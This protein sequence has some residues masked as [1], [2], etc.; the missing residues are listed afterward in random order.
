MQEIQKLPISV[1]IVCQNEEKHIARL[2]ESCTRFAEVVVVDSGSTDS[3]LAILKNYPVKLFQHAWQGYAKQKQFALEQCTH[4]WVLNLDADEELN[5]ALVNEFVRVMEK[6]EFA[7][8]RCLRDDFFMGEKMHPFT[9]KPNNLRFYKRSKVSFDSNTL[10]HETAVLDGKETTSKEAFTHYGY[11][12]MHL[13][14]EKHNQYTSLKALEKFNK[15]KKFSYLKLLLIY[16][17][18]FLKIYLLQRH[19]FSGMRGFIQA[20]NVAYYSFM[21]EAKLYELHKNTKQS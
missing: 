7:G 9:K 5:D 1:F 11:D 2:L 13:L 14:V 10:V 4:A 19:I 12:D 15:G 3:T 21:K 20:N 16:P 17:L 18:T 8:L 6:D